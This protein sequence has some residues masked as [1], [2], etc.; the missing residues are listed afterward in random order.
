M[1]GNKFT[2]STFKYVTFV[3]ISYSRCSIASLWSNVVMSCGSLC[4][5]YLVLQAYEQVRTFMRT[6]LHA[7]PANGQLVA[8]MHQRNVAMHRKKVAKKNDR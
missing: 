4:R 3:I 7:N 8:V 1:D 6:F 5:L 2:I